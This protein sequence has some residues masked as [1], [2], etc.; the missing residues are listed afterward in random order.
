MEIYNKHYEERKIEHAPIRESAVLLVIKLSLLFLLPD[1][2]YVSVFYVFTVGFALPVDLHHH[3][4]LLLIVVFFLKLL[5]QLFLS[6]YVALYWKNTTYRI[7][8]AGKYLV[9]KT[10]IIDTKEE[11][12]E[13]KTV[14][15]IRVNQSWLGRIFNYGDVSLEISA[16]GGYQVILTITGIQNP[17]QYEQM[18]KQCL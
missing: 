9:K 8:G 11:V 10:G 14:R 5:I 6:L 16:S 1:M 2:L 12:Y 3:I 13:F 17:K 18:I 7:D 4:S 15:L